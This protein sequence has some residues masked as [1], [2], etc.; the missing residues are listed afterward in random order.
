MSVHG[1][2]LIV[3]ITWQAAESKGIMR[4]ENERY[5]YA[6]LQTLMAEIIP[7][8]THIILRSV[9]IAMSSRGVVLK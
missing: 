9:V 6:D 4:A 8:S 7:P 5:S 1:P 2:L 3:P